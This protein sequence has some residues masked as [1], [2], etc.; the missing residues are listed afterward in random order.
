[1]PWSLAQRVEGL[2][3]P[4]EAMSYFIGEFKILLAKMKMLYYPKYQKEPKINRIC[5]TLLI[6]SF[7]FFTFHPSV[8]AEKDI[9]EK[10][11]QELR[12]KGYDAQ[13]KGDLKEALSYYVKASSMGLA[14]PSI[15]NDMGVIYEQLGMQDKAEECYLQALDV[16]SH[17]LPTYTNL[18]YFYEK[19]GKTKEAIEY[20]KKR[21]EWGDSKDPWTAK[22]KQ[23]LAE[24]GKKDPSVRKWLTQFEAAELS[25]ELTRKSQEEFYNRV[26]DAEQYYQSGKKLAKEKK[27]ENAIEEYDRALFLT[28]KN[29][30][31]VDARNEARIAYAQKKVKEHA[32]LAVKMLESGDTFSAK[33]EIR[34]MLAN[35][36]DEPIIVSNPSKK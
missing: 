3:A 28:P 27:Y 25:R 15:F 19:Q 5:S 4:S 9:K 26:V 32:D 2:I 18:A 16:D 23:G 8:F 20:L 33:L 14:D 12:L 36:P 6:F 17:Y 35:I 22:A 11:A 24:L 7:L 31:I 30:K 34:R 29:P 1:M 13:Q 10:T 21:I